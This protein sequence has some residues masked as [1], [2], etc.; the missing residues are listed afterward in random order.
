MGRTTRHALL[1]SG[2]KLAQIGSWDWDLAADM[3]V[4]SDNLFRLFGLEPGEIRPT[5][6]YVV[7]RTHPD[8]RSRV[9][10]DLEVAR[11]TGE[12]KPLD[13]RI[14]TDHGEVRHLRATMAFVEVAD[15]QRLIGTVQD[16]TMLYRADR[17]IAA[18][19]AVAETFSDW[20][21]LK[22][23]GECL[24]R[25]LAEALNCVVSSLWLPGREGLAAR[26]IWRAP[27][28]DVGDF[29]QKLRAVHLPEGV[30]LP[31]RA[32]ESREPVSSA[33]LLEGSH[34]AL[35]ET[36]RALGLSA[37]L[38]FPVLHH[39]EVLAVLAFHSRE[40]LTSDDR[41][42]RSLIGIG[43]ELGTFFH[44]RRCELGPPNLTP[45]EVDV[46][47]LTAHGL[48]AKDIA[49]ALAI[50]P[51]TV[52]THHE[53]IYAKYGVSDRASAVAKGLR[54]GLIE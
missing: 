46:L 25:S 30:G 3:L 20:K 31:G 13:H 40:E 14:L 28:L 12:L 2:E 1:E 21:S 7:T 17:N 41:L 53:H 8:D 15:R 52:R 18:H 9:H 51:A 22:V 35:R 49:R 10:K 5:P 44:R 54:L 47:Q 27:S 45:R 48:S 34:P 23:N 26:L 32:W 43:H 37:G 16:L 42:M 29:E 24:L 11:S 33:K 36:V 39:E 38:A 4:W 19:L 50:S 6:E